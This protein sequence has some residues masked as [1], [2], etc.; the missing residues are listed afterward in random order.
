MG[1]IKIADMLSVIK[2]KPVSVELVM[3]GRYCPKGL[4]RHA[5]VVTEM[6]KIKHPFDKGVMARK[7]I[8]Y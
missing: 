4:F 1:L 6:K 7:G 3:T 5:D 2:Q 8:E